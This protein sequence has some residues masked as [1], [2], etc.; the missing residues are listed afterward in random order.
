MASL[1]GPHKKFDFLSL[2]GWRTDSRDSAPTTILN[3]FQPQFLS[4][5]V[6][7]PSLCIPSLCTLRL[8]GPSGVK[9]LAFETKP[10]GLCLE[11]PG[12]SANQIY[13]PWSRA[14]RFFVFRGQG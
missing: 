14:A 1:F 11:V 3:S 7:A 4:K 9:D 2:G 8:L 12:A 6:S 5:Q 13:I 10:K